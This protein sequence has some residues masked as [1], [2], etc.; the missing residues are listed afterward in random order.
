[1]K[2]KTN[3][4]TKMARLMFGLT[5]FAIA[6][7]VLCLAPSARANRKPPHG[8]GSG[9]GLPYAT[10]STVSQLIADLN[11][12]NSVGGAITINLAPGTTFDLKSADNTTDGG[13]GC[14]S[15]APR[16][17]S[18]SPSSATAPSSSGSP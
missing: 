11:Y 7:A 15:S 4:I 8:G 14:P 16:N 9:G 12:A 1:M 2:N 17:P 5:T 3:D 13:T 6:A 10:A 18:L